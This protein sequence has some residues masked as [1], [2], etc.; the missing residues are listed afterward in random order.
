MDFKKQSPTIT[1]PFLQRALDDK[2]ERVRTVYDEA[3]DQAAD[4][5]I[6]NLVVGDQCY[7]I[8]RING[9]WFYQPLYSAIAEIDS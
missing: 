8:H 6:L 3:P 9:R 1:D 7:Q 4:G 5:T 2:Q